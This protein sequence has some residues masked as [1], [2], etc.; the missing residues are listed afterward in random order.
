MND[1]IIVGCIRFV[2][3]PL[4]DE[5]DRYLTFQISIYLTF[6]I[7]YQFQDLAK[8]KFIIPFVTKNTPWTKVYVVYCFKL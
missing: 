1:D 7:Q 5:I 4:E 2:E 3:N 8:H 6:L